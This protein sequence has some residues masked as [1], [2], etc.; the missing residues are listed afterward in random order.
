MCNVLDE[1]DFFQTYHNIFVIIFSHPA[2]KDYFLSLASCILL[3][4]AFDNLTIGKKQCCTYMK[5]GMGSIGV[6]SGLYRKL[7]KVTFVVRELVLLT[8]ANFRF[9][10]YFF[11]VIDN[12][13]C[14]NSKISLKTIT[15]AKTFAIKFSVPPWI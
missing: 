1:G 11:H 6:G 5:V 3:I 10:C 15:F 4:A 12:F 2:E 9:K 7:N 8:D 14:K 13:L